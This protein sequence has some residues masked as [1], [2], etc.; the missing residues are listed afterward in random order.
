MPKKS[1]SSHSRPTTKISRKRQS[2]KAS[3]K[4]I[5][6]SAKDSTNHTT[7]SY[8]YGVAMFRLCY[9]Y[10]FDDGT[11]GD[12]PPRRHTVASNE[13]WRAFFE[14]ILEDEDFR[15]LSRAKFVFERVD[16]QPA[17]LAEVADDV[18]KVHGLV[19][20]SFCSIHTA[21][22]G[23][24]FVPLSDKEKID[25]NSVML[26]KKPLA[27][28]SGSSSKLEMTFEF[29]GV[30]DCNMQAYWYPNELGEWLGWENAMRA[31]GSLRSD[32]A[33]AAEW[34]RPDYLQEYLYH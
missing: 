13:A 15:S 19:M 21:V 33:K 3:Q 17:V 25:V 7:F 29:L 12:W 8:I 9:H 10:T 28:S 24:W 31:D 16:G 27:P 23:K 11:D 6:K 22:S 5:D 1:I 20:K 4:V 30:D 2:V 26:I 34:M 14:P 18:E 32:R